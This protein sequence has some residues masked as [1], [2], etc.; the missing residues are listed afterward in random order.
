MMDVRKREPVRI[1]SAQRER[2]T[3][4]DHL[5]D[6]GVL[7]QLA[8]HIDAG[9]GPGIILLLVVILRALGWRREGD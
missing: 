4:M 5:H 7:Q 9:A 8:A 3:V 2:R 6:A 1:T